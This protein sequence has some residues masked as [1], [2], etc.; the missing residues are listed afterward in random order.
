MEGGPGRTPEEASSDGIPILPCDSPAVD[1]GAPDVRGG[2]SEE[3]AA[4]RGEPKVAE[5]GSAL[6]EP[7]ILGTPT[8]DAEATFSGGFEPGISLLV[9]SPSVRES[10]D[11]GVG[12]GD[13][14]PD[15]FGGSLRS[16]TAGLEVGEPKGEPCGLGV[17]P[18][19]NRPPPD[20]LVLEA[21][22]PGIPDSGVGLG[23]GG[24]EFCAIASADVE[25]FPNGDSLAPFWLESDLRLVA[26]SVSEVELARLDEGIGDEGMGLPE[27]DVGGLDEGISVGILGFGSAPTAEVA[28]SS[29]LSAAMARA[30]PSPAV[31]PAATAS[32]ARLPG[33]LPPD[34]CV[35]LSSLVVSADEPKTSSIADEPSS[36]TKLVGCWLGGLNPPE[37]AEELDGVIDVG[38]PDGGTAEGGPGLGE[39]EVDVASKPGADSEAGS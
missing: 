27:V 1:R 38:I 13:N 32:A 24:R 22:V 20:G 8:G 35:A 21:N 14:V 2:S 11:V 29:V 6:R 19:P 30:A 5:G 23:V 25:P 16:S 36:E 37:P 15:G 33:K 34:F 12:V 26:F 31:A 17:G 10:T 9:E 18:P 3:T 28:A 39:P 7:G 4:G